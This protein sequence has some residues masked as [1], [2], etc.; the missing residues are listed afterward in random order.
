M[1]LVAVLKDR[2]YLVALSVPITEPSIQEKQREQYRNEGPCSKPNKEKRKK[3]GVK[4]IKP[5]RG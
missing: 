1:H 3:A 5:I 4:I 2:A